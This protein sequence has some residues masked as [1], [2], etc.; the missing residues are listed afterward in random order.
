MRFDEATTWPVRDSVARGQIPEG[1]GQGR[2]VYGGLVATAAVRALAVGVDRPLRSV[3]VD[4]V[5]P[6]RVG[7]VEATLSTL[8][9]GRSVTHT[10]ARVHQEGR[11]C[12][13]VIACF[14]SARPTRV[15]LAPPTMPEVAPPD[16]HGEMPYVEGLMPAF[17]QHFRF[18]WTCTTVPFTGG[19]LGHVQGWIQPR[20]GGS[21]DAAGLL[22]MMDAWPPPVWSLAVRPAPGS[23]LTWH[24]D[25][26][27]SERPS[28]W[29]LYDA[30][31]T[32]SAEGYAD[33]VARLWDEHGA[34][35][36]R[37]RQ[38]FAEFSGR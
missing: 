6:A 14:G 36:A 28:T 25:V 11:L 1:W 18:R 31:T 24:A 2:S 21:V 26:L 9:T 12:A 16:E 20:A 13:V 32:F 27:R 30:V 7:P 3:L 22:G 19:D 17:T 8:R 35:V 38:A 4:F 10:E 23:T 15:P 33:V 34:L 37:G 29:W 5:G